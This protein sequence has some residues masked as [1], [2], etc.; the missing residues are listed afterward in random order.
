MIVKLQQGCYYT[1]LMCESVYACQCDEFYFGVYHMCI[2]EV[3][4][5]TDVTVIYYITSDKFV[6][7]HK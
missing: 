2:T 4:D 1:M 7:R 3:A 5:V 6:L